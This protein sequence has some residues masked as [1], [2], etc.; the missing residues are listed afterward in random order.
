M[1]EAA[2]EYRPPQ[3]A[4]SEIE[5]G[6]GE[7]KIFLKQGNIADFEGEAFFL[8]NH[9]DTEFPSAGPVYDAIAEKDEAL[10]NQGITGQSISRLVLDAAGQIN[11]AVLTPEENV[12]N[13]NVYNKA[14][15]P[16]QPYAITDVDV[17]NAGWPNLRKIMFGNI[18]PR[19]KGVLVRIMHPVETQVHTLMEEVTTLLTN[20]RDT[21]EK[22][23]IKSVA[24]PVLTGNCAPAHR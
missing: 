15:F 17:S 24:M 14:T 3:P 18:G 11:G 6:A 2:G 21:V 13:G 23:G 9:S 7:R 5:I 12:L 22:D 4:T 8:L 19:G 1:P 20:M 16:S 10:K